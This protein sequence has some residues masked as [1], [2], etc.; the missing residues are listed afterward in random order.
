[1]SNNV[2]KTV[3]IV[4]GDTS[5]MKGILKTTIEE[6]IIEDW[7]L[8]QFSFMIDDTPADSIPSPTCLKCERPAETHTNG[9]CLFGP[10][11]FEGFTSKQ[12]S[13]RA[14]RLNR[15][16]AQQLTPKLDGRRK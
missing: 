11:S 8:A 2:S 15:E 10:T 1:M 6:D 4:G 16:F 9:K 14:Q 12:K 13:K 7:D 3:L 5:R